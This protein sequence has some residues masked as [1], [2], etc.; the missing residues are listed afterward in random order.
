MD[1]GAWVPWWRRGYQVRK[2]PAPGHHEAK[3]CG[4][5]ADGVPARGSRGLGFAQSELG[6]L[7]VIRREDSTKPRIRDY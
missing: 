5:S 7:I 1:I 2:H 4:S 6:G 3:H